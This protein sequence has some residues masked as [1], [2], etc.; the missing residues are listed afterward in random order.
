MSQALD[1]IVHTD[2]KVEGY[3]AFEGY[4]KPQY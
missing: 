1:L 4:V 3:F 2:P